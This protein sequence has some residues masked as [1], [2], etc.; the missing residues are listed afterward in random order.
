MRLFVILFLLLAAPLPAVAAERPPFSPIEQAELKRISEYLNSISSLTARFI[1]V[2]PN[3]PP[4]E[5][6]FYLKKPGRLRFEYDKP[7]P[8][9]VIADGNS[10]VVQNLQ[11]KTTDRY[12]L[13]TS[14]LRMLLSDDT[15][16]LDDS[17][18]RA[19]HVQPGAVS[20]VA[21]QDSGPSQGQITLTFADS[22]ASL[23]LRQW[24][25]IDAQGMRTV[26]IV[27]DL[28]TG[29]ELSPQLFVVKNLRPR[30]RAGG[31]PN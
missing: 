22:G 7:S 19:V 2:N 31:R 9:L 8:V 30:P 17:R 3:G 25:V 23:E 1:Q 14:P 6:T 11:L 28:Q 12:P 13:F 16:L 21:R 15:D 18:I 4:V 10:L 29:M 27:K 20:V 5:G 24:I 26:V